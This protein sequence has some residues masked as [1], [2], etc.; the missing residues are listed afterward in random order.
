[1]GL[2][3]AVP[4]AVAVPLERLLPGRLQALLP[5]LRSREPHAFTVSLLGRV[6]ARVLYVFVH[7]GILFDAV[8]SGASF[9]RRERIDCTRSVDS[10]GTNRTGSHRVAGGC[11]DCGNPLPSVVLARARRYFPSA[12]ATPRS[13]HTFARPHGRSHI[14]IVRLPSIPADPRRHC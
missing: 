6:P 10:A 13:L 11:G 9:A 14:S 5:R 12:D 2:L 7:A 1:S 8:L 3:L 4:P